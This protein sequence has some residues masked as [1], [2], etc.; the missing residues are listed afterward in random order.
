M[1]D[2]KVYW[3]GSPIS[4]CHICS[5][6]ID[7]RFVDGATRFGSWA[8]MCIAC[9]DEFGRGVGTGRGQMYDKQADGRWLKT[10]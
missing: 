7:R 8:F 1:A 4:V 3:H 9:H 5:N 10:C 6:P 2:K